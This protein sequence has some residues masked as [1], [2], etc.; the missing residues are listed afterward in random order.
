LFSVRS[1]VGNTASTPMDP[2]IVAGL[3]QIW[4]APMA[5]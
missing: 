3:A 4:S 2:V 1:N 5:M